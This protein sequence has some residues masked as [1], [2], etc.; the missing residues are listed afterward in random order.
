MYTMFNCLCS[1]LT[2][3]L[4]H[5]K[6]I[7]SQFLK[8]KMADRS[9]MARNAIQ[10]EFRNDRKQP[11]CQ[12]FQKKKVA[13]RSEMARNEKSDLP[14]CWLTTTWYQYIYAYRQLCWERGNIHCVRPLG[15]MHTILVQF[16][17]VRQWSY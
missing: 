4:V 2:M 3:S 11:L 6:N 16:D 9:E 1:V 14:D 17:Y 15:R 7:I 5:T 8:S 13:Y 12:K 10:S